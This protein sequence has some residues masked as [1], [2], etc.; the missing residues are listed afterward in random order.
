MITKNIVLNMI[1][2]ELILIVKTHTNMNAILDES[3]EVFWNHVYCE[4]NETQEEQW[5]KN[6]CDL[7]DISFVEAVVCPRHKILKL[8]QTDL[9]TLVRAFV[10]TV[11]EKR[12]WYVPVECSDDGIYVE[13]YTMEEAKEKAQRELDTGAVDV[14]IA[15]DPEEV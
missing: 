1:M 5:F 13:A 10:M 3:I 14:Q 7:L 6:L 11:H 8:M 4:L 9:I 12:E 15:D 2:E